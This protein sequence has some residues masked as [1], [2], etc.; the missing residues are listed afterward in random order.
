M[1]LPSEKSEMQKYYA[2]RMIQ[3]RFA[4]NQGRVQSFYDNQ[5]LYKKD[6]KPG[7]TPEYWEQH[8]ATLI[9]KWGGAVLEASIHDVSAEKKGTSQNK[10]AQLVS[11]G[12][13]LF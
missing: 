1:P 4:N 10:I 12:N 6:R 9:R 3:V 8:F 7:K 11:N 2:T 5:W 13:F